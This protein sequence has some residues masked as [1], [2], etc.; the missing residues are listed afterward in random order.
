[1]N[2]LKRIL[3]LM[4]F[5][6]LSMSVHANKTV[7]ELEALLAKKQSS[8]SHSLVNTTP[9]IKNLAQN[10]YFVFIYKGTCPHC[11]NFAPVLNDFAR[12]FN[13]QVQSYSMDAT[14]IDLFKS[15]PLTP[16]LFQTFYANSGYKP[17]VPALFMVNRHTRE[18]YAV[19]F[20]EAKDYELARRV[21]EL[22][23]HI[24]EKYHA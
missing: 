18:A 11:H 9:E 17:A 8:S 7:D 19:L 20:G 13:I 4:L 12:T 14:P 22:F 2:D 15:E 16:E 1:M 5:A 23:N 3:L 6:T 10:Y 24:E 21:H